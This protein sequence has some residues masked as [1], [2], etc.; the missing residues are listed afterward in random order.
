M[1]ESETRNQES[2]RESEDGRWL[3]DLADTMEA[4]GKFDPS[5]PK[6]L[7]SVAISCDQLALEQQRLVKLEEQVD[8]RLCTFA[9]RWLAGADDSEYGMIASAIW[10]LSRRTQGAGMKSLIG[11][12]LG[13]LGAVALAK[14]F[15]GGDAKA[16]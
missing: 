4:A 11:G 6:R 2:Q 3:E 12:G 13:Q 1:T 10:L 9:E 8:Q 5:I 7:R 16:G 15:G 14:M